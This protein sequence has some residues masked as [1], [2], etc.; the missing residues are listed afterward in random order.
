MRPTVSWYLYGGLAALVVGFAMLAFTWAR[1]AGLTSVS[2]QL[3]YAMS[4]GG[5]A[6]V[7]VAVGIKLIEADTIV[8][9][10]ARR[11]RQLDE[12]TAQVEELYVL[13]G[14]EPA[15][16]DDI[17]DTAPAPDADED[18]QTMAAITRMPAGRPRDWRSLLR[19]GRR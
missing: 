19:V 17:P 12:L 11:D 4:G 2:L 5:A 18:T 8:R 1:V 10:A 13:L 6:V 9:T 16:E 7:L 15:S 3:P 14:G